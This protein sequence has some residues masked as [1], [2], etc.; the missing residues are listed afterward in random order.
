MENGIARRSAHGQRPMML[1]LL[2]LGSAM[3]S[4]ATAD[5]LLQPISL[6]EVEITETGSGR[7]PQATRFTLALADGEGSQLSTHAGSGTYKIRLRREQRPRGAPILT[8]DLER[9]H[10][11]GQTAQGLHLIVSTL[12]TPRARTILGK[13]SLPDGVR[14]EVAVTLR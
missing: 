1:G 9:N 5:P 8:C 6:A 14:L 13:V 2:L 11:L 12:A 7:S 10:H 4:I 3:G